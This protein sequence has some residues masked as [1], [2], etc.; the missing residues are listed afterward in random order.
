[1]HYDWPKGLFPVSLVERINP[2]CF[3]DGP[4][5][6]LSFDLHVTRHEREWRVHQRNSGKHRFTLIMDVAYVGKPRCSP[7]MKAE[8][9]NFS[10]VCCLPEGITL[11]EAERIMAEREMPNGPNSPISLGSW[12]AK[13][14]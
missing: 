1:M 8:D 11:E 5:R 14:K 6:Y 3:E 12:T 10:R 7:W 4:G 9:G 2:R 13:P